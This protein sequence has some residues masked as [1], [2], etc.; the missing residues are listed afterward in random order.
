MDTVLDHVP[1]PK[2]EGPVEADVTLVGWG[3]T[4]GVLVEAAERLNELGI[5]TNHLQISM[6]VPFHVKE[7]TDILSRSKKIV[8]VE[9]NFSG[10]FARHLRAE[11]GL[12]A[13]AHI[14][15]YDGEP[16]EPKHIVAGVKEIL[17]GKNVVQVLSTELGWQTDHPT[18]TSGDWVGRLVGA[19]KSA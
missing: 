4:W 6:L 13:T 16:F 3:S 17:A 14:R 5:S 12:V 11:T 10:Q 7:V 15:K 2:L 19:G 1:A 18:G 8:I 9:N